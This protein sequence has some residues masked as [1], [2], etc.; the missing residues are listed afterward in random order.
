MQNMHY[1]YKQLKDIMRNFPRRI[2]KYEKY[3][4]LTENQG[5]YTWQGFLQIVLNQWMKRSLGFYSLVPK[6]V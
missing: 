2:V 3:T 1:L 5:L 4:I 6:L